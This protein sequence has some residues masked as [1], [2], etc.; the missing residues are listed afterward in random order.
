MR[1]RGTAIIGYQYPSGKILYYTKAESDIELLKL[2]LAENYEKEFQ[3]NTLVRSQ[4]NAEADL[5]YYNR[6]TDYNYYILFFNN[7]WHIRESGE[8]HWQLLK[9]TE[10]QEVEHL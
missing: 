7:Q 3:A 1:K 2:A 4:P 9:Q 10:P 8:S 5:P 6:N